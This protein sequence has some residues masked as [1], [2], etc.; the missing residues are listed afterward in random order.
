MNKKN[1]E[2]NVLLIIITAPNLEFNVI[3]ENHNWTPVSKTTKNIFIKIK[4]VGL[5]VA[6]KG[7][8]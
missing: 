7:T 2:I 8:K 5:Y 4:L 1:R 6:V 3:F